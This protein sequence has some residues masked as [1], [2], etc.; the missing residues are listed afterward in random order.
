M[1]GRATQ[2]ESRTTQDARPNPNT[3]TPHAPHRP[4]FNEGYQANNKGDT[5]IGR[6]G[7]HHSPRPSLTKPHPSPRHPTIHNA[8]TH[9]HNEG[10]A[11]RGYPTTQKSTGTHTTHTPHTWQR[12]AGDMIAVLT[13]MHWE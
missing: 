6:E 9:H 10:G 13:D 1:K 12:T 7:Q 4:P 2:R 3:G 8:P 5:N 11:D